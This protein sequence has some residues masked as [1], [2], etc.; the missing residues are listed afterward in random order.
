MGER[1]GGAGGETGWM[2][3]RGS[4]MK[5]VSHSELSCPH[6]NARAKEDKILSGICED[7]RLV[8]VYG[9]WDKLIW[10]A[11]SINE[12]CLPTVQECR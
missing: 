7:K 1:R 4:R 11:S 12:K 6:M 2:R 8:C 5:G 3:L 9:I 10:S